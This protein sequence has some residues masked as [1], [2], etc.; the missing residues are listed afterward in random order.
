M[1]GGVKDHSTGGF[2]FKICWI[3]LK[4]VAMELKKSATCNP[5]FKNNPRFFKRPWLLLKRFRK[6]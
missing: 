4:C 1:A 6:S 3:H 2:A 5:T